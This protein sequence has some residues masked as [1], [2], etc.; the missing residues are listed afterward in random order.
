ME[1]GFF[2]SVTIVF[3]VPLNEA[4]ALVEPDSTEGARLWASYLANWTV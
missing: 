2:R 3:N 4:L 1:A